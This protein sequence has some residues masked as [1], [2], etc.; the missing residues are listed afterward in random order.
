MCCTI[1]LRTIVLIKNSHLNIKAFFVIPALLLV[2]LS[3]LAQDN[4]E[5]PS[6]KIADQIYEHILNLELDTADSLVEVA[7]D[8]DP[9]DPVL[10][11]LSNY[12]DFLKLFILEDD[13]MYRY[14]EPNKKKRIK[15]IKKSNKKN[16]YFR[17]AQAEIHLQ[18]ALARLK[19]EDYYK[20]IR[21]IQ[22]AN[23]LLKENLRD[24]PDFGL[25]NKALATIQ[26]IV[27]FVPEDYK[28]LFEFFTGLK[29]DPISSLI[30]ISNITDKHP[31]PSKAFFFDSYILKSMIHLH[32][33]NDTE[34]AWFEIERNLG[35]HKS[36]NLA[37]FVVAH[38]ARKSNR[39]DEAI[40]RLVSINQQKDQLDFHYLEFIL[41]LNKL[42]RLDKD[43]DIHLLK[44]VNNFSGKN[45]IKEAYQ[46]LAWHALLFKNDSL[47]V[48]SY[49]QKCLDEGNN[50][51]E[52]DE[53]A[54]QEA[55]VGEPLDKELLKI[56]LLFDGAYYEKALEKIIDL[57][58]FPTYN[59][60]M[61][62]SYRKARILQK[63]NR[64][65]EALTCYKV[66]LELPG[67]KNTW[68]QCNS[69]L[70][71]AQL[72]EN[73]GA[74]TKARYYYELCLEISPSHYKKGLHRKA[75]SGLKRVRD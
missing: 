41:G 42:R 25:N 53:A 73:K 62:L 3:S 47:L 68:Q 74:I 61:E 54:L 16:P 26:A 9:F 29:G 40:N 13:E 14:Y 38:F 48:K 15:S 45:Y 30:T 75:K 35:P 11:L 57:E 24:H 50:F 70:Q 33:F 69:A 10:N 2:T 63:L 60:S 34:T 59:N 1:F 17:Y 32:L 5:S 52:E 51:V 4:S 8:H 67:A 20:S 31:D 18:W 22:K 64:S 56:R 58:K 36:I 43:A 44:F 23:Q 55:I 66:L 37:Q 71:I 7:L 19:F 72:Y 28:G 6:V 27:A 46:K 65:D 49:Y 39:T 12:P 21:E